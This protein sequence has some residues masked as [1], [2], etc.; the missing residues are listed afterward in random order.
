[1]TDD[2]ISVP[3]EYFRSMAATKPH[4]LAVPEIKRV[5]RSYEMRPPAVF[6]EEPIPVIC[7]DNTRRFHGASR[8][9]IPGSHDEHRPHFLPVKKIM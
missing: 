5:F 9:L 4:W 6:E 7:P 3:F 1:M 8:R 2:P